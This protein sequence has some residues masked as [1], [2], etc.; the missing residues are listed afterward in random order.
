MKKLKSKFEK[1]R[2]SLPHM[3]CFPIPLEFLK[4]DFKIK[5]TFFILFCI[6]V[7]EV[8]DD[9]DEM[10]IKIYIFCVSEEIE[11]K[12]IYGKLMNYTFFSL[13][14]GVGFSNRKK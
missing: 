2:S 5:T 10:L 8:S 1:M 11:K 12:E 9:D 6:Y 14:W 4:I 7:G 13:F 3:E